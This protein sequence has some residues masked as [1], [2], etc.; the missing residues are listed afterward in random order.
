MSDPSPLGSSHDDAVD[1]RA[2]NPDYRAATA[3]LRLDQL[4][5]E[6]ER[7]AVLQ[8]HHQRPLDDSTPREWTHRRAWYGAAAAFRRAAVMLREEAENDE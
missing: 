2:E 4:A 8:E 7:L 1:R 6:F 5:D 3:R